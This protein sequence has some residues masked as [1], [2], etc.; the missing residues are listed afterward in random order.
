MLTELK[1]QK[2]F[3][4]NKAQIWLQVVDKAAA[5]KAVPYRSDLVWER[6]TAACRGAGS[7]SRGLGGYGLRVVFF[8]ENP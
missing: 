6:S 3:G 1:V 7:R 2:G 4:T 8:L 5:E